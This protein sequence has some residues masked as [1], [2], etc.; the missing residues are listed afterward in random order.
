M[1]SETITHVTLNIAYGVEYVYIALNAYEK[2]LD[3]K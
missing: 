3:R 2:G 1:V